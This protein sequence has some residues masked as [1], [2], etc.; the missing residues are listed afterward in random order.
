[1][2][3]V[4]RAARYDSEVPLLPSEAFGANVGDCSH[5]NDSGSAVGIHSTLFEDEA[6]NIIKSVREGLR[7]QCSR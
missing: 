1:M 4:D 3:S 2:F 7:H 5:E 6:L